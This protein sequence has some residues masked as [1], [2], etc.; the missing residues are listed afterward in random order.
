MNYDSVV[1]VCRGSRKLRS[2]SERYFI[3]SELNNQTL[4][5]LNKVVNVLQE[6]TF[7]SIVF[8]I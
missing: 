6:V 3:L 2:E 5:L 8:T 7:A 4:N 1:C